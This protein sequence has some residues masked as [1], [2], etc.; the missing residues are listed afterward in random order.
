MEREG[1]PT[2]GTPPQRSEVPPRNVTPWYLDS[3]EIPRPKKFPVKKFPT[4]FNVPTYLK[5][6]GM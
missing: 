3:Q 6:K 1:R 4:Y 2:P 5:E